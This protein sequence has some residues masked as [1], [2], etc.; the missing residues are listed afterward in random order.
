VKAFLLSV[1]VVAAIVLIGP[2]TAA[3]SVFPRYARVAL[4]GDSTATATTSRDWAVA[5]AMHRISRGYAVPALAVPVFGIGVGSAMGVL[6]QS[7]VLVSIGLTVVAGVVLAAG[8]IPGQHRILTTSRRPDDP[9]TPLPEGSSS[10]LRRLAMLTGGFSL[11]WVVVVVL[12]ILRPGS[13][14]GA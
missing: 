8:I 1:H 5:S 9:D 11:I 2:I 7:W 10:R 13:T 12:M 3:A 14:T 4:L 6:G